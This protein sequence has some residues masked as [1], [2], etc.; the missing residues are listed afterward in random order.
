MLKSIALKGRM[1]KMIGKVV[2]IVSYIVFIS[3]AVACFLGSIL[4]IEWCVWKLR[5]RMGK[6]K[7]LH[8]YIKAHKQEFWA[9]GKEYNAKKGDE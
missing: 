8:A 5:E 1:N 2:I 7:R 9:W 3:G 6:Y 4:A